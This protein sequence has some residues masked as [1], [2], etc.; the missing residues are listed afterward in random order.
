[1][2]QFGNFQASRWALGALVLGG[3]VLLSSAF[4]TPQTSQP[5]PASNPGSQHTVAPPQA[6]AEFDQQFIDMMVPHHQA[7][8]EMAEIALIRAEHPEIRSLAVD[9]S[10][11][12]AEEISQMKAWRLAWYGSDQTPSMDQMPMLHDMGTSSMPMGTMNMAQE[13]E[14]LRTA[15]EPFD[16]AFI[17]AMVPHHQSAIDAAQLAQ[18]R[19]VHQEIKDLA[20][21]IISAQQSEIDQMKAWRLA[22]YGAAPGPTALP[23]APMHMP[24]MG[25]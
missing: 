9:I 5:S 14:T 19:A 13:V 17:D 4:Q 21:A 12:Q 1:M 24:E 20:V 11:S 18:T 25:H 22:W 8:I 16:R 10:R 3:A 6:Q 15:P 23:D 2:H 7:A